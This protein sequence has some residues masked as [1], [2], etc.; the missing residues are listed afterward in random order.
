MSPRNAVVLAFPGQLTTRTGG[1]VY[2]HA[3]FAA[4]AERGWEVHELSLP[5]GLAFEDGAVAIATADA[6][7]GLPSGTT[8]VIDGLAFAGMAA[9]A[10]ARRH[11]LDIVALVHHPLCLETGMTP[12]RAS[13][14]RKE[15]KAALAE[16]RGVIATSEM[17]ARALAAEFGVRP[18][19]LTVA[20]PGAERG[21]VG[22]GSGAG[23]LL[24]VGTLIPRKGHLVLLEA[25][26]GLKEL[27]WLL[28][29]A[30]AARDRSLTHRLE[31]FIEDQGLDDRV[32]LLGEI[33]P[34]ALAAAYERADAFVS[35]S[36]YEG[37]GM[38]V[39]DALGRGLPVI[40][41]A[42]GAVADTVPP[43]AGI[44]VRP[45]DVA[46]LRAALRRYLTDAS[47][48]GALRAGALRVREKLPRWSDTAAAI[49]QALLMGRPPA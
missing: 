15:E 28:V 12:M 19:R 6:L 43:D 35:A 42:G 40:A 47:L 48:R 34:E 32:H 44:L 4:L 8:V 30:G 18:E 39:A 22:G 1:Y 10:A 33:E 14:L 38:A 20:M 27:D 5:E 2:D 41:T 3:A 24:C 17:T 9:I 21:P 23:S 31:A 36:W 29:C 16:A 7:D 37:Y 26:A 49:E 46:G 25:L 45:G 13:V 11:R